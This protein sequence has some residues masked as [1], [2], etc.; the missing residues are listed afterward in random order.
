MWV[1][2]LLVVGRFVLGVWIL[3]F[4]GWVVVNFGFAGVGL[5]WFLDAGGVLLVWMMLGLLV[6]AGFGF[7]GWV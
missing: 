3:C 4:A 5:G 2:G 7:D 6:L 1:C